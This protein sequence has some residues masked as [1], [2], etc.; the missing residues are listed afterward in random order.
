M[1]SEAA[2]PQNL[3]NTYGMAPPTGGEFNPSFVA[4]RAKVT[5]KRGHPLY[6]VNLH[7]RRQAEGNGIKRDCRACARLRRAA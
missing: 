7:L 4:N 5:C 6:G 1:A 2:I 3:A